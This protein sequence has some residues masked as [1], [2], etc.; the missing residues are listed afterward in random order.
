MG[1]GGGAAGV[2]WRAGGVR[3]GSVLSFFASSAGFSSFAGAL[4]TGVAAGV[5]A[6]EGFGFC[7]FSVGREHEAAASITEMAIAQKKL[8]RLWLIVNSP[9]IY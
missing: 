5:A 2:D 7:V 3:T 9:S 4:G 8:H 6:G 1:A